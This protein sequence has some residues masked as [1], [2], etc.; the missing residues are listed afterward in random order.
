MINTQKEGK[1]IIYLNVDV[2]PSIVKGYLILRKENIRISEELVRN[3]K[4][5]DEMFFSDLFKNNFIK[6]D[7]TNRCYICSVESSVL[8]EL[9]ENTKLLKS[10]NMFSISSIKVKA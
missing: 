8:K 6:Y 7:N 9:L 5:K 2:D 10:N 1:P 4:I 3:D